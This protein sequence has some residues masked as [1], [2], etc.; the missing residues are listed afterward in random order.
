MPKEQ[1]EIFFTGWVLTIILIILIAA[2]LLI[3]D[4]Y[5]ELPF[6]HDFFQ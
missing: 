5:L 6:F 4:Y 1:G 3:F 2:A